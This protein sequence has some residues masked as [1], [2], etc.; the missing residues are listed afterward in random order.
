MV[1]GDGMYDILN[2]EVTTSNRTGHNTHKKYG[3]LQYGETDMSS[4]D[5]VASQGVD[6]GADDYGLDRWK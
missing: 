6:S 1:K 2:T 5:L 4:F 3:R